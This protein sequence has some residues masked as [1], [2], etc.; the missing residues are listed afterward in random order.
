MINHVP[1]EFKCHCQSRFIVLLKIFM[2]KN[3]KNDARPHNQRWLAENWSKMIGWPIR[4]QDNEESDF[5]IF[6][7]VRS[8]WFRPTEI[9]H[10]VTP[11]KIKGLQW[12]WWRLLVTKA[13]KL[14]S[15]PVTNI[16]E[17]K[18]T[19]DITENLKINL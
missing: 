8:Q 18:L 12:C 2:T 5:L 4:N 15:T 14:S 11:N 6:P 16:N 17:A 19:N 1:F 7:R 3:S 13:V 10:L 9:H